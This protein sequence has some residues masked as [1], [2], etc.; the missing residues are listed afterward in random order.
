MK[1]YL[2]TSLKGKELENGSTYYS[3]YGTFS[4]ARQT[5]KFKSKVIRR[6]LTEREF[7][8][9]QYNNIT[10]Q[11]ILFAKDEEI[12]D[13]AIIA[14]SHDGKFDFNEFKLV[15]DWRTTSIS[16]WL[17]EYRKASMYLNWD[18]PDLD[19][20]LS[21]EAELLESDTQEEVLA[22]LL[23]KK[24]SPSAFLLMLLDEFKLNMRN[25]N[26]LAGLLMVHDWVSGQARESLNNFLSSKGVHATIRQDLYTCI[27]IAK[28]RTKQH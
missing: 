14:A 15:Y 18:R 11:S 2:N 1:H 16:N 3:V 22:E 26:N 28:E 19:W 12:V 13:E 21:L 23:T 8:K 9:L 27:D 7:Q 17:S 25:K 5:Y 20:E 10:G 6:M 4:V 24:H